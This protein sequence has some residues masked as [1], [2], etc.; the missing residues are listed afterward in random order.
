MARG[1]TNSFGSLAWWDSWSIISATHT[2]DTLLR[3]TTSHLAN[4]YHRQHV[5]EVVRGGSEGF[6]Y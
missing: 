3:T 6:Q 2:I 1:H 4:R 5:S